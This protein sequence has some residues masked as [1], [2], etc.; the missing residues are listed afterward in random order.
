MGGPQFDSDKALM[1]F[2]ATS[3]VRGPT[4]RE[5]QT[6]LGLN[7]SANAAARIERLASLGYI[8]RIDLGGARGYQ[9]TDAGKLRLMVLRA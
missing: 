5:L 2:E 8:E 4:V 1:A 6:V 7:S 3:R 9:L